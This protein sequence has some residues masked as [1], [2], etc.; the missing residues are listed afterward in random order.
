MFEVEDFLLLFNIRFLG[1]TSR[2]P[3]RATIKGREI[4]NELA[5]NHL[6]TPNYTVC[7]A[8]STLCSNV[9]F[10]VKPALTILFKM[11]SPP[12]LSFCLLYSNILSQSS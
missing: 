1:E 11:E 2:A 10:S 5:Y 9:N 12:V 8:P 3:S 4:E 7:V 6:H